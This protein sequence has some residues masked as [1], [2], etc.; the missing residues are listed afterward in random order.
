MPDGAE[1]PGYVELIDYDVRHLAE[2]LTSAP[3]GGS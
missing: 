1:A 3:E 2:A